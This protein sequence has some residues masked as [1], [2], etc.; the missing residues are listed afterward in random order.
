MR[1]RTTMLARIARLEQQ[2]NRL[3]APRLILKLHG[4]SDDEVIGFKTASGLVAMR[5]P[6]EALDALQA[7]AWELGAS[8][9]LETL[10]RPEN[11]PSVDVAEPSAPPVPPAEPEDPFALA[12]IGRE[13]TREELIRMGAIRVPPERLI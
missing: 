8:V 6:G 3:F 5:T 2:R 9:V 11:R 4:K 1:S 13:A 12:G 7:R 10:Y